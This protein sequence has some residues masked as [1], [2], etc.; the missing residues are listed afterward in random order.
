[1]DLGELMNADWDF[2]MASYIGCYDSLVVLAHHFSVVIYAG[3]ELCV[4]GLL[5]PRVCVL[6]DFVL[7]HLH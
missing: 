5:V 2:W 7:C 3:F 6:S 4:R 1:M